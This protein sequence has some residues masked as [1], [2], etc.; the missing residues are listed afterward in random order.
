MTA[1]IS[2][3]AL[4]G[5][6]RDRAGHRPGRRQRRGRSRSSS[7]SASRCSARRSRGSR[8]RS[9][10]RPRSKPRGSRSATG[11]ASF[12][13]RTGRCASRS[14]TPRSGSRA[15]RARRSAR[16]DLGAREMSRSRCQ[17]G[18]VLGVIGRNGAGKSTLLKVLTR[19]TTPTAGRAE[20]RGRVGSLLE[21]GTG[22]H[23]ELTGRENVYLNGAILGHE[24]PRDP[25][26]A[27]RDRRLL[28]GRAVPRHAGEAVLERD[29][30]SARVLR[31]RPPRAGDPA[32]RRGARRRRRGVPGALPRAD[33]G[34]RRHR[35]DGALRLA[36]H[37]GESRSSATARSSRRRAHRR[38]TGRSEDVVAH[39]LQTSARS[40]LE[41]DV[42]DG[43]GAPATTSCSPALGADRRPRRR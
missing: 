20:I 28:R 29:V 43:R 6:R 30:R 24:A 42:A 2:G 14:S 4:G 23:P 32:R 3:L 7:S 38:A 19:I 33:G 5:A 41:P 18:E 16:G 9:D 31:R 40:R 1:V 39:Y 35:T 25:A 8:T 22:F 10:G 15:R 26:E 17:Q 37:A 21:V 11:S 34:F 12:R 27:S 13:P 36:Q